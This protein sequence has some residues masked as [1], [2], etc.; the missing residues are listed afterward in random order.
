[1]NYINNTRLLNK[2][3]TYNVVV[4]IPKG[5]KS[6]FELDEVNFEKLVE[7]RKIKYKYPFYYGC[8]P[9]TYAGDGDALDMVLITNKKFE[10]LDVVKVI[11][12]GVVKTIDNNEVDDKIIVIPFGELLSPKKLTKLEEKA[13]KF[14]KKYKG[15]NSNTII[16]P[17]Y[18]GPKEAETLINESNKSF[19][20]L[21]TEK[22]SKNNIVEVTF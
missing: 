1:M 21:N 16:D 8:F 15:K 11:P 7:V 22:N 4:E 10:K 20:R 9:Q 3:K 14:L 6:K 12:I 19:I 13:F 5:T 17:I 2:N 18:Y